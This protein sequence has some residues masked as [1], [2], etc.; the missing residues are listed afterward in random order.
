MN[1]RMRL[2]NSCQQWAQIAKHLPG[3]T[4]NEVKNFWNS[5]VKKKLIAQGLDPK[6]HNLIPAAARSNGANSAE[7]PRFRYTQTSTCTP[8][9]ISSSIKSFD[10]MN[11]SM[12]MNPPPSFHETAAPVSNF[13]YQDI[14][15]LMSFK[16]QNC[17]SS[18]T[19]SL[20]HSNIASSSFH[21]PGFVDDCTWDSTVEPLQALKQIE[22][23]HEQGVDQL[24]VQPSVCKMFFNEANKKGSVMEIYDGNSGGGA[25]FDLEM[26]ENAWLP[27]GEL[28][29]G[30]FM[31]QLQWDYWV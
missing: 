19:S 20:D 30:S 6:T 24:Q 14:H 2:R 17:F 5:C 12:D 9:T 3:R 27:C 16:D 25:T 1:V 4:D 21:Q 15:V 23:G 29:G 18:S 8:F 28:S 10:D 31:D 11:N 13:Q 22:V 7:P 26:L